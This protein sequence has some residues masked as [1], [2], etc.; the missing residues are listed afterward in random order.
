VKD[1]VDT[2]STEPLM[3]GESVPG[4]GQAP[5][6]NTSYNLGQYPQYYPHYPPTSHPT[7]PPQTTPQD[8]NNP[9]LYPTLPVN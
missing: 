3:P 8:K 7:A 1:D 9:S 5:P 4:P 6:T 2:E